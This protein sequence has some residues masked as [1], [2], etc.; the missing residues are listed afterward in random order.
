M[1]ANIAI[2]SGALLYFI[3]QFVLQPYFGKENYPHF[4]HVMAILFVFNVLLMLL[5]G[6][7]YPRK[8]HYEQVYTNQ[9]DITPWKY[10]K[11]S[12][13]VVVAIVVW[14]YVYFN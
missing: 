4:L 3:S 10:A 1:A 14:T 5:I 13:I 7:L 8:E 2:V 9:V 12:G 6:K 11:I